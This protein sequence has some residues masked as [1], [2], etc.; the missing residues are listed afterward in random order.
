MA[1]IT[2]ARDLGSLGEEVA[3]ELGRITGYKI[4]DREF[5]EARLVQH[6]FKLEQQEKLDEKMP[7]FW[8]S[9]SEK[10]S[11]YL[12]CLKT[13]LF[14]EASS[15]EHIVI[16]RGGSAIFRGVPNHLAVRVT[17]PL[18]LRIERAVDLCVCDEKH[19]RHVVEQ[20]D[21][22]RGGF[23]KLYFA[24]DWNDPC[25]FDLTI[26]TERMSAIQAAAAIDTFRALVI[27]ADR[28]AGGKKRLEDLLLGQKIVTEIVYRKK[29][30]IQGLEVAADGGRVKIFGLS[31]TPNAIEL[32]SA[33][34]KSVPGVVEVTNEIQLVQEFS[35]LP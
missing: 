28:E 10:Q 33:A 11:D 14:E 25:S 17:A 4:V 22:D 16:G 6:G 23:N 18:E 2:I 19:A 35:M 7:G 34:A 32:A 12:H 15:G 8:A 21:H 29:A 20:S 13:V 26:N 27:D 24:L 9:L 3:Q 30:H 5:I 1:I 31:N